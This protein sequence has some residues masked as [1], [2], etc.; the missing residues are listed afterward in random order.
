MPD[1]IDSDIRLTMVVITGFIYLKIL[2]NYCD[3]RTF[4]QALFIC[5][6]RCHIWSRNENIKI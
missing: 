6:T 1:L 4:L 3:N 5:V 2:E